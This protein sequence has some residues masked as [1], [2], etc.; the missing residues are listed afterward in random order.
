[1][2]GVA[3]EQAASAIAAGCSVLLL[4]EAGQGA[5]QVAQA[6]A[7]RF[8]GGLD[9]AMA[10]Y[11]GSGKLFYQTVAEQWGCPIET[12]PDGKGRSRPLTVDQLKDEILQNVGDNSLLVLP[13]SKRLPASARYWVEDLM[14][15]GVRVLATAVVNPGKDIYLDMVEVELALPDD[16][17]IRSAM[18]DEAR[19]RGVSLDEAQ[20]A[21]LQPLAGRNPAIARKVVRNEALGLKQQRP[22]HSQY[23]DISPLILAATCTLG[24][25]R[26]IGMGTGNKSLYIVGGVAMMIGLSLKY[27][28]K[29]QGAKRRY[30]Q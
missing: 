27:L 2:D 21:R 24:L 11:K 22:E 13:E 10:M 16:Q 14:G 20:L 23:L 12:E 18:R 28:G 15:A 25:L 3:L 6:V 30:G 26:F 8:S 1:V 29:I 4:G 5:N 9:V 19:R 7:D 17:V